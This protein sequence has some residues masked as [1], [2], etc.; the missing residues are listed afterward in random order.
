MTAGGRQVEIGNPG[1]VLFPGDGITKADLAGYYGRVAGVQFPHV[2]GRPVTMHRFPDGIGAEGFYQQHVP[3][4]FPEWIERVT[5][6]GGGGDVTRV[7]AG[8]P[9]TFVYLAS[10]GCITPHVWLASADRPEH[11]DRLVLDLDPPEGEGAAPVRRAA[12]LVGGLLGDELGLECRLMTTGSKGYHVVVPLDRSHRFDPV[13]GFAR[14]CARLLAERHPGEVTVERRLED[15]R[16]RVFL[17]WLRNA[18][19]QTT[20]APY[21]VRALPGAPVAAPID[22]EELSGTDPGT[23]RIGNLFRR[24]GQRDDPWAAPIRPADLDAASGR[25]AAA[26]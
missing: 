20:V 10:Q 25:L 19:G 12:R 23:Y 8:D 4:H 16:G 14:R 1:K 6:S 24:L 7:V 3:D 13:R 21:A 22:W 17:D 26:T 15:R 2:E 11:P 5:L 18:R 9:A